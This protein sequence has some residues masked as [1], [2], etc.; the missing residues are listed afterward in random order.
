ML[1]VLKGKWRITVIMHKCKQ[2][3]SVLFWHAMCIMAEHIKKEHNEGMQK[4][5]HF[6]VGSIFCTV[7]YTLTFICMT[8]TQTFKRCSYC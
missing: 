8:H 3:R 2:I 5:A 6:Y 4:T 1:R 7:L